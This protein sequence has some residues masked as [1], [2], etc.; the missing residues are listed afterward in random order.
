[1]ITVII[2]NNDAGSNAKTHVS[3]HATKDRA[4]AIRRA[5]KRSFSP[6]KVGF[7]Q[8]EP[9]GNAA[10]GERVR[11]AVTRSAGQNAVSV[12]RRVS[13]D[14]ETKAEWNARKVLP[15]GME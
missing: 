14:T 12:I 8:E 6:Y 15:F 3:H 11:G 9:S 13:I 10:K 1:M 2:Y 5:I 4:E 7:S